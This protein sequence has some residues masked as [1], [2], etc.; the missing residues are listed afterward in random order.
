V[1]P[2]IVFDLDGT[3][4][5]SAPDL[6]F[7]INRLMD[8]M[9]LPALDLMT[10]T[11][12]IGHGV[13]ELVIKSLAHNRAGLSE[14]EQ[15][16]AI[17]R[18]IEIYSRH[19]ARFCQTYDGVKQALTSLQAAGYS[20]AI[21]TNKAEAIARLVSKAKGFEVFC[22]ALIGGD[23]LDVRKPDP[24]PLLAA[25]DALKAKRC[26]YVGDSETDAKTAQNAGMPF[27]LH[28]K[29]YRKSRLADMHYDEKFDN[30]LDFPGIVNR[31]V[32]C[33]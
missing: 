7:C 31:M 21:C 19:P 12:F 14:S 29:G 1:K 22:P 27:I 20:M 16:Q 28:T 30:W 8:E 18:Y 10:V 17:E 3:L 4:V 23:S 32:I 24:A 9:G 25:M 13:G 26:L 15:K 33:E 6:H 11:G 2:A 5:D